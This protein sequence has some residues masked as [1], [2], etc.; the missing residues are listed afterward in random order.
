LSVR[1]EV[2]RIIKQKTIHL[3]CS[4]TFHQNQVAVRDAAQ[5]PMIQI[6]R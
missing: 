2:Q 5:A 4:L 1:A 6:L 3:V